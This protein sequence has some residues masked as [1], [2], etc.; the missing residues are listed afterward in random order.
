[1]NGFARPQLH[2]QGRDDLHRDLILQSEDVLQIAVVCLRPEVV[3]FEGVDQLGGNANTG[4]R[5]LN[6]ALQNIPHAQILAH[7]L[8]IYCLAL[9]GEGGVPGNHKQAG[10][11]GERGDD[12]LRDPVAEEFLLWVPGQV[13]KREHGNRWIFRQGVLHLID[14]GNRNRARAQIYSP[15]RRRHD[16]N[17]HDRYDPAIPGKPGDFRFLRQR[18]RNCVRFG[19]SRFFHRS[20]F[21]FLLL[22]LLFQAGDELIPRLTVSR[23]SEDY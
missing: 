14:G 22:L 16:P 23:I 2:L 15:N 13:H 1:M 20:R 7:P 10:D 17:Q 19:N 8:H 18:G 12:L 5:P 9:I 21:F 6:T 3:P 4:G 11:P